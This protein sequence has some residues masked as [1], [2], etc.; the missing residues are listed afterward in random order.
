MKFSEITLMKP[1]RYFCKYSPTIKWC[2]KL[3][4]LRDTQLYPSGL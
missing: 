1:K 4:Q 3:P 2:L